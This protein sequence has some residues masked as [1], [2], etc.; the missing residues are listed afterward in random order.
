MKPFL[1]HTGQE[2]DLIV[3]GETKEHT[4]EKNG[5][6]T[7]NKGG[8]SKSQQTLEVSLLEDKHQ[9]PICSTDREP[10][11][12]D[13]FER[14][15]YR[16][17]CQQKQKISCQQDKDQDVPKVTVQHTIEIQ[18]NR[19]CASGTGSET[20][21]YLWIYRTKPINKRFIVGRAC[22]SICTYSNQRGIIGHDTV[23]KLA[24]Q[25]DTPVGPA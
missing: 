22:N 19:T 16:A 20:L 3:H 17:K 12:D 4:E 8:C 23:N 10:V 18:I 15:H 11:H 13:G 7:I 6:E 25:W 5:D 24:K 2:E 1:S 21:L 9:R 14:Q